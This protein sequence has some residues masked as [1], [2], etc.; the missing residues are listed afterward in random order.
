MESISVGGK[1]YIK[2]S[3]AARDLGYTADYVG[4]LCRSGKVEAEL[5][6]RT[7]YVHKPSI[8][9]HRSTRYRSVKTKSVESLREELTKPDTLH[10]YTFTKVTS[11][12]YANDDAELIPAVNK[13]GVKKT[14]LEVGLADAAPVKIKKEKEEYTFN[15]TELPE[16][17][18][19]GKLTVSDAEEQSTDEEGSLHI[20]PVNTEKRAKNIGISPKRSAGKNTPDDNYTVA[21]HAIDLRSRPEKSRPVSSTETLRR[22]KVAE[23]VSVEEEAEETSQNSLVIVTASFFASAA[24]ACLILGLELQVKATNTTLLSSYHFDVQNVTAA[25]IEALPDSLAKAR[26]TVLHTIQF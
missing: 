20:H 14:S 19:H 26:S 23:V 10:F 21:V 5:V 3:V 24:V 15:T 7:W 18:F 6:G 9:S 8:Q 11:P 17:K 25:A 2:A 4:Q 13:E 16:I 22:V 1:N 12:S